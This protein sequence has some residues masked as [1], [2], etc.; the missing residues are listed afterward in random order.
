MQN[1][2]I[3]SIGLQFTFCFVFCFLFFCFCFLFCFIVLFC[4]FVVFFFLNQF[5]INFYSL[6]KKKNV[7]TSIARTWIGP[8]EPNR[9]ATKSTHG[10]YLICMS[11]FGLFSNFKLLWKW[12]H[13]VK[14]IIFLNRF[15][16]HLF[17]FLNKFTIN[18][19]EI[20]VQR[21]G[22]HT[23]FILPILFTA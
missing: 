12:L 14:L 20:Q 13:G 19:D 18:L 23:I 7:I 11:N 17:F 3:F 16:I 4:C 15:T 1:L 6:L 21:C 10:W 9:F 5:T 2:S 22:H 8:K